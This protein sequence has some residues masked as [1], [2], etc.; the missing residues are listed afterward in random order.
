MGLVKTYSR[1][2]HAQ[3]RLS[4]IPGARSA[5]KLAQPSLEKFKLEGIGSDRSGPRWT[6]VG[7][8][9]QAQSKALQVSMT[10]KSLSGELKAITGSYRVAQRDV[11]LSVDQKRDVLLS[12]KL[13]AKENPN[14]PRAQE[15]NLMMASRRF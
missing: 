12:L 9:P 6:V 3:P 1:R 7:S 10:V 2:A 11:A 13:F 5:A 8:V 4:P 15:I 14:H